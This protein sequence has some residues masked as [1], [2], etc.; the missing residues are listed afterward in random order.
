[1]KTST[2]RIYILII[3]FLIAS[4]VATI[5]SYRMHLESE[6]MVNVE[7]VEM[8]DSRLGRFFRDQL[9]LESDQQQM[10]R[11]FRQS[12]HRSANGLLFEMQKVRNEMLKEL[13]KI[14]PKRKKLD[15]LASELGVMHKELKGL[16]FDYY[17]NMQSVLE[18]D[19]RDQ[20]RIIFQSMLSDE[21]Y[22]KTP[23]HG[24]GRHGGENHNHSEDE[25]NDHSGGDNANDEFLEYN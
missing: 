15:E 2:K 17:F 25:H 1:M 18:G 22:A 13:N 11:E 6:R 3:A 20:M 16:T 9:N 14:E 12:Y 5:F 8:P 7:A 24:S 19:Q 4:N 10:F 23:E 21:G